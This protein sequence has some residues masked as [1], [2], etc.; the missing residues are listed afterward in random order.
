LISRGRKGMD[1]HLRTPDQK[2]KGASS[3]SYER[4]GIE[5]LF[6]RRGGGRETR[7]AKCIIL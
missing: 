6:Y 5:I 4:I 3:L 2:K 7:P 1:F